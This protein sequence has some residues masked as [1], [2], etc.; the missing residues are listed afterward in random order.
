MPQGTMQ[1]AGVRDNATTDGRWIGHGGAMR[2]PGVT[3]PTIRLL[4][5]GDTGFALEQT[6]REGWDSTAATFTVHISH[7][8]EGCFIAEFDGERAG[9]VT[10]TRYRHTGW[11]GN[12][13]VTP[14]RRGSGIGSR[15]MEHAIRHLD[16]A[17]VGTIRL[18]AD[19][20]GVRIYRRMGFRDEFESPRFRREPAGAPRPGRCVPL[21]EGDLRVLGSFDEPRFGDDRARLLRLL[22]T[23]APAA[24][25]VPGKGELAGY[26]IVQPS[27]VGVRIGP[28]VASSLQAAG[29]LLETALAAFGDRPLILAAPGPN[30]ACRDLLASRGF[31]ETSSSLRMI[32]GRGVGRGQH[33]SV[34][35]LATGAVG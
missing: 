8:P 14:E 25:R 5:K 16:S 6:A 15:L 23:G 17:G 34:Y 9:L 11:I 27:A 30:L 18:E 29:E 32:R 20:M 3:A 35:A 22:L 2:H 1:E 21:R 12:L 7:D 33:E 10:T 24:F 26:L 13:I 31:L 4:H 19:P 28:W